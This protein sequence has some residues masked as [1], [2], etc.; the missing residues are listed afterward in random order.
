MGR[1]SLSEAERATITS[2]TRQAIPRDKLL[3]A[4]TSAESTRA[5]ERIRAAAEAGAEAALVI[6]PWTI[7]KKSGV[8]LRRPDC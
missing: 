2:A 1:L 7:L 4:G 6:A 5:T 3:V 8:F